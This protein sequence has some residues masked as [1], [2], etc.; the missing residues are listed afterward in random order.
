MYDVMPEGMKNYLRYYGRHFNKKLCNF[1]ISQMK[2]KGKSKIYTKQE[3]DDLMTKNKIEI[4]NNQLY[5]YVY[6]FNMAAKDYMGTSLPD[7]KYVTIFTKDMVDDEDAVDGQIWTMWYASTVRRGIP[8][9]WE[10]ML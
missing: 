4:K 2:H 5:D 9:E 1:A 8:I 3:I 6:V 7:E 10:D